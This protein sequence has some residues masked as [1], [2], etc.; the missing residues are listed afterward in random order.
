[1]PENID[2][3][4]RDDD[5]VMYRKLIIGKDIDINNV[6]IGPNSG[7]H[8]IEV[9]IFLGKNNVKFYSVSKSVFENENDTK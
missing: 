3:R 2:F 7:V 9:R 6:V 8:E 1:M 5:M 4:A